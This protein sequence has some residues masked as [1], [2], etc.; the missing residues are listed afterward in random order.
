MEELKCYND[1][2]SNILTHKVLDED[3]NLCGIPCC[4]LDCEML[5]HRDMDELNNTFIDEAEINQL[6]K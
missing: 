2:C 1:R 3:N 6:N 4:S 5:W